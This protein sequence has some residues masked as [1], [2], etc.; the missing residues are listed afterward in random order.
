MYIH[1]CV[2]VGVNT[3]IAHQTRAH[4][5]PTFYGRYLDSV[6]HAEKV[7]FG[8][9]LLLHHV[10]NLEKENVFARSQRC[11]YCAG[12]IIAYA[13]VC[14]CACVRVYVCGCVCIYFVCV[15]VCVCVCVCVCV[16]FVRV[17]ASLCMYVC[18]CVDVWMCGCVDVCVCKCVRACVYACVCVHT[19]AC[20]CT[21]AHIH[22]MF[23][24][25][26]ESI[27]RILQICAHMHACM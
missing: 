25:N 3:D 22:S 13:S 2:C 7:N 19:Y 6:T 26:Y 1:A 20:I 16:V 27:D 8:R 10:S 5:G 21:Y 23:K 14:A 18:K 4:N 15:Y 12:A 24:I 17:R 9:T 11:H